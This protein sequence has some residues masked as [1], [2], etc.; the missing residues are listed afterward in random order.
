M[1]NFRHGS[2]IALSSFFIQHPSL[3]IIIY[4][5]FKLHGFLF[6]I[7]S[8]LSS[9]FDCLPNGAPLNRRPD[10]PPTSPP[11]AREHFPT[12]LPFSSLVVAGSFGSGSSGHQQQSRLIYA[13]IPNVFYYR[14]ANGAFAPLIMNQPTP[15]VATVYDYVVGKVSTVGNVNRLLGIYQKYHGTWIR[16]KVHHEDGHVLFMEPEEIE[17]FPE[18][19]N[20]HIPTPIV[21][22]NRGHRMPGRS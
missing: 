9:Q 7:L 6:L 5:K 15:L 10:T 13:M 21:R 18:N 20:F 1:R 22:R 16:I 4:W 19:Y 14:R 8:E 3:L 12:D 2:F 11:P 17:Q